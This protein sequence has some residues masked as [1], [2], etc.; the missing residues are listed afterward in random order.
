M[1]STPGAARERFPALRGGAI[2]LDSATTTLVPEHVIAAWADHHRETG[3]SPGRARS[4]L[5]AVADRRFEE[6]RRAIAAFFGARPGDALVFCKSATEAL[7]LLAWGLTPHVPPSSI[8][9]VTEAE[10]HSNDLPWRRLARRTGAFYDVVP[11]GP[12]GAIDAEYVRRLSSRRL[13]VLAITHTSNVTGHRPPIAE[14]ADLARAAGAVVVVDAAQAAAHEPLS[15]AALGADFC[16]VSAHKMYGP[17]GIAAVLGSHAGVSGLDPLLVGGGG[18]HS[19]TPRDEVLL[20]APARLEAGTQDAAAAVAWAAACRWIAGLGLEEIARHEAALGR[21]LRAGLA[22]VDGVRVLGPGDGSPAIVSFTLAGVHAHDLEVMLD[23]AGI[24]VRSGHMCA[25]PYLRRLGVTSA[26]RASLA[27][28]TD[29]RDVDAL[30]A[31]IERASRASRHR[32]A[33]AG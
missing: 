16:V 21:R 15:A 18:V 25:Q 6:A 19:V 17:K 13:G 32:G 5:S 7:N 33:R 23:A 14:F 8:V 1:S 28:H 20:D 31:A 10:H 4:G 27:V 12:D 22:A 30:I 2:Y 24:S 26:T 3:G 9:L 29:E 11:C